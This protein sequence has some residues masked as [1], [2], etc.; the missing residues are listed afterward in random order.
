M[1]NSAK[2]VSLR[3]KDAISAAIAPVFGRSEITLRTKFLTPMSLQ[4]TLLTA[5]KHSLN[6]RYMTLTINLGFHTGFSN[7][8][9]RIQL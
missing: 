2:C 6:G 1:S 8:I 3:P 7:R 4:V 9:L 5:R